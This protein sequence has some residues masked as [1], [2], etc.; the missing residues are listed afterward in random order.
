[1]EISVD[2]GANIN[3]QTNAGATALYLAE[4]EAHCESHKM[5][6]FLKDMGRISLG[7]E[8]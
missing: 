2:T 4:Q 8:F 3:E 7:P 6:K 5:V 1:V